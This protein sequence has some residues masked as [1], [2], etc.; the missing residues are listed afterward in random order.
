[1]VGVGGE[2]NCQRTKNVTKVLWCRRNWLCRAAW[3]RRKRQ[4]D[5]ESLMLIVASV[6]NDQGFCPMFGKSC[7]LL[8]DGDSVERSDLSKMCG[9]TLKNALGLESGLG[10]RRKQ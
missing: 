6:W 10:R 3:R 5:V 1:V 4:S 9:T 7:L 8:A 2:K